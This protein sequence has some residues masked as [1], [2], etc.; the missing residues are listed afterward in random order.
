[1]V[2]DERFIPTCES[3]FLVHQPPQKKER[4]ELDDTPPGFE[5]RNIQNPKTSDCRASRRYKEWPISTIERIEKQLTPKIQDRKQRNKDIIT[6]WY[7]A[8]IYVIEAS[9]PK[10]QSLLQADS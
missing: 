1:M 9:M 7:P 2:S 10:G 5:I 4:K 6:K 8:P 3:Y